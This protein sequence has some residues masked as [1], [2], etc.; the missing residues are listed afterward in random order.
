MVLVECCD[1]SKAQLSRHSFVPGRLPVREW[2][3]WSGRGPGFYL[4]PELHQSPAALGWRLRPTREAHGVKCG[5]GGGAVASRGS[6]EPFQAMPQERRGVSS[7]SAPWDR[8]A[9]GLICSYPPSFSASEGGGR[10]GG[11]GAP[12]DSVQRAAPGVKSDC[13]LGGP[14]SLAEHWAVLPGG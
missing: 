2:A 7:S 9:A 8:G 4:G 3:D 1:L 14:S 5:L 12:P 6:E 13:W 10:I 11:A